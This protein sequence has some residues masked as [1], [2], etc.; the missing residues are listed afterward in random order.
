MGPVHQSAPILPS[1]HRSAQPNQPN[2]TDTPGN[3]ILY[4]RPLNNSFET[5]Y[6]PLPYYPETLRIGRQTNAKTLPTQH[7]GFFDSKVL[8]RQHAEVW[9]DPKTGR[10]WIRDVKSSNGT[11]VNS[12]RLSPENR[13]SEAH[14]LR[15]D[16]TLELGIDIYSEDNKSILHHKVLAKV[17]HAGFQLA[18]MDPNQQVQ[19][20]DPIMGGGLMSPQLNSINNA[21]IRGRT[22]SQTSRS[23]IAGGGGGGMGPRNLPMFLQ[24][25]SVEQIVKR[26]N[27]CYGYYTKI[28]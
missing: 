10:V 14:E 25:V 13:E 6:I 17:E 3:S 5:K 9:A 8:S 27:V 11:F 16:D 26:V 7:N 15:S 28:P 4:L 20:I 22:V 12:Q 21:F 23:S 2:G 18:H 1:Q 19:E 24:S